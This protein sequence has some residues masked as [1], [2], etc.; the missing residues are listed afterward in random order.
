MGTHR[1]RVLSKKTKIYPSENPPIPQNVGKRRKINTIHGKSVS[2]IIEDEI[3]RLQSAATNKVITFQ[4]IRF[5]EDQR[6][7]FRFGYYMIGVKGRTIGKWV[8]GQFCLML[9]KKDL[10]F[11][12]KEA[13]KKKWL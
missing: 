10:I 4:K 5:E 9:P 11:L 2:Y 7:E 12:I 13:R 8:W 1:K 6:I 3:S